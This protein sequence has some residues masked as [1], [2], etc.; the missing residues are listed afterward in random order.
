EREPCGGQERRAARRRGGE[1]QTHR[2]HNKGMR[3]IAH[4]VPGALHDLL[5]DAPLSAGKVQFAWRSAVG[6]AMGR[7]TAVNLAGSVLLVD[8]ATPAWAREVQRSGSLILTRMQR[9]LGETA[10]HRIEIRKVQ[11]TP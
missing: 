3:P 1:N 4:A 10:V 11:G 7:V 8:A 2:C 6:P 5:R 9:L